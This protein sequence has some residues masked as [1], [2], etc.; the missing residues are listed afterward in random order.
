[1]DKNF[2]KSE[3]SIKLRKIAE[4]WRNKN[5]QKG[6]SNLFDRGNDPRTCNHEHCFWWRTRLRMKEKEKPKFEE[7]EDEE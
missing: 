4:K 1:M 7:E 5:V 2:I 6:S 3:T